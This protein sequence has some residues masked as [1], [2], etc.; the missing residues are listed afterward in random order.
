MSAH[1]SKRVIYAA[2]IG[3]VL[4]AA[5]KFAAA[6]FTGSS[7]M[8]SEAIHSVVDT[9]NGALLLYGMKRAAR[10][11]DD[12]HPYGHARE[13]YFWSFIVAL[14]IFTMGGGVSIHEGLEKLKNPEPIKDAYVNFIILG[15]SIF[16]ESGSCYVALK[17]FK[18]TRGG[19][20]FIAALRVSKDPS[21]FTVLLEDMA[22]LIG[23]VVAFTGIA[24]SQIF[25]MPWIDGAT[26]IAIGFVL[27][28]AAFFLAGKTKS[29][30]IGTS[31]DSTIRDG[32]HRLVMRLP[33]IER[34]A[35][36][37]T[38]HLGPNDVLVNITCDFRDDITAAD[39]ERL[40]EQ[41]RVEI[42]QEFPFI[43]H[44]FIEARSLI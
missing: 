2:L 1:G 36:I 38:Q 5:T 21:L 37:M 24:L 34:M 26:S 20:S 9:G 27:F 6:I 39:V 19:L 41:L 43:S 40:S 42:R 15:L 32:I 30:L 22:A 25:D 35:D 44:I 16:F 17:E 14:L 29:L 33:D 23:L 8:F 3:N 31:V 13:L 28:G 12:L 7:A 18:K 4:I 11:A 10:P